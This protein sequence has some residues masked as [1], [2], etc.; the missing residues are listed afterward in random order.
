MP[1]IERTAW[2]WVGFD[3]TGGML[4]VKGGRTLYESA[5]NN[6]GEQVRLARL[7]ITDGGLRQVN[8]YVDADTVLEFVP[9]A[10]TP[11]AR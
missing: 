11:N 8:R 5:E 1:N 7:D 2:L 6:G 3:G 9:D 4:R 10:R